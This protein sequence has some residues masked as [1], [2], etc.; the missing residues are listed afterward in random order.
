MGK[1]K[2][3]PNFEMLIKSEQH[4]DQVERTRRKK[5][6]DSE[7]S[8]PKERKKAVPEEN[9]I[10]TQPRVNEENEEM[11]QRQGGWTDRELQ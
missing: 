4:T 10:N 6:R 2:I 7:N 5:V 11:K 3:T 9:A 1:G 8:A